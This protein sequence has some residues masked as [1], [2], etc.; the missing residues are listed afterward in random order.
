MYHVSENNVAV[1]T[2]SEHSVGNITCNMETLYVN[3]MK[4]QPGP[5]PPVFPQYRHRH[6]L[7]RYAI[8]HV[9]LGQ[10]RTPSLLP[11]VEQAEMVSLKA[12]P[13]PPQCPARWH[14]DHRFLKPQT[15]TSF[16]L[17][18]SGAPKGGL[19]EDA[20]AAW[21]SAVTRRACPLAAAS[22]R[23]MAVL[24]DVASSPP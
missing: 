5:G 14:M 19:M 2:S 23:S 8:R 6:Y 16:S 11:V 15:L 1:N 9:Q 21:M 22:G 12:A 4:F 20:G 3:G 18:A 13:S 7:K 24:H 17:L 10:K